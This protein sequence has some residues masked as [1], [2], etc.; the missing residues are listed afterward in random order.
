MKES[1]IPYELFGKEFVDHYVKTR[2]WEWEKFN[3]SVTDWET[4]RYLEII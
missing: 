1:H 3:E 2:E 4:K